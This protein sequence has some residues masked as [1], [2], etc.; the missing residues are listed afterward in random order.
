MPETPAVT[1]W[2]WSAWISAAYFIASMQ[3]INAASSFTCSLTSLPDE[4]VDKAFAFFNRGFLTTRGT[5]RTRSNPPDPR[6]T[7]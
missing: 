5:W 3:A 6:E 4:S 2:S 1:P 7:R